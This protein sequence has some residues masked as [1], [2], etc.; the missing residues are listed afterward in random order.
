MSVATEEGEAGQQ[1]DGRAGSSAAFRRAPLLCLAS[2]AALAAAVHLFVIFQT[3]IVRTLGDEASYTREAHR[4]IDDGPAQLLPGRMLFHHRPPFAFHFFALFAERDLIT[5]PEEELWIIDTPH[6]SWSPAMARFVRS[7]S[8][9]HLLLLLGTGVALYAIAARLGAGPVG[10]NVAAALV[11][12][13]PRVGF[14]VQSLWTEILHMALLAGGM[15]L[16]LSAIDRRRPL[17][18][19]GALLRLAVAGVS[20]A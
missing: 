18:D 7:V 16:V 6:E 14:Y 20:T 13:N 1:Q 4:H 17:P 3:P 11:L 15:L 12:L 10:A 9:A 2:T 8:L 19:A 5:H